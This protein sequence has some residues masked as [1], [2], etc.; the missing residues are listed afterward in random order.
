MTSNILAQYELRL[1]GALL[2]SRLHV[3]GADLQP[4]I[5]SLLAIE[6]ILFDMWMASQKPNHCCEYDSSY[7]L[8]T[9]ILIWR[10]GS[11]EIL[12]D[13]TSSKCPMN[14]ATI[15]RLYWTE[16]SHCL[17]TRGYMSRG[18]NL[19]SN[20]QSRSWYTFIWNWQ[21][22]S[23]CVEVLLTVSL[24]VMISINTDIGVLTLKLYIL[25]TNKLTK[26]AL[27]MLYTLV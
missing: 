3:F 4:R 1:L 15:T 27:C 18:I 16:N 17:K 19:N 26:Q 5:G 23:S 22:I 2:N 8:L 12:D 20:W 10:C 24:W 9:P 11:I 6:F 7:H 13:I 25:H 21:P 14:D